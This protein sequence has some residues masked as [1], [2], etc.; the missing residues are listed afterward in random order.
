MLIKELL[1][2]VESNTPY[3]KRQTR[4]QGFLNDGTPLTHNPKANWVFMSSPAITKNYDNRPEGWQKKSKVLAIGDKAAK[5]LNLNIGDKLSPEQLHD[6][7]HEGALTAWFAGPD[8]KQH[9]KQSKSNLKAEWKRLGYGP[10]GEI[11][12]DE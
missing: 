1:L 12:K 6:F 2:L 5:K 9:L 11:I 3:R 8:F 4:S 10:N 7:I